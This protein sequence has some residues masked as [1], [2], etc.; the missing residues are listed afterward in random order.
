MWRAFADIIRRHSHAFLASTVAPASANQDTGSATTTEPHNY[1]MQLLAKYNLSSNSTNSNDER[2][3]A[4]AKM[5]HLCWT[6]G[7]DVAEFA[8]K[9]YLP[10]LTAILEN[11][12]ESLAVKLQVVKTI[13]EFCYGNKTNQNLARSLSIIDSLINQMCTQ[14]EDVEMRR[15]SLHA[16]F[17]IL[18]DN[19]INQAVTMR[20]PNLKRCLRAGKKDSWEG[21]EHNEGTELA[22]MLKLTLAI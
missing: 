14:E 18:I 22:F 20:N 16:L 13:A 12:M 2:I 11:Y 7:T 15:W 19:D 1:E 21:W 10:D 8:G 3:R 6:G 4:I 17:F 5:G 9:L